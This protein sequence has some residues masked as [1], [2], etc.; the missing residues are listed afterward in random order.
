MVVVG[1][2]GNPTAG[3]GLVQVDVPTS[4]SERAKKLVQELDAELKGAAVLE[5]ETARVAAAK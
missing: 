5:P 4:L 2:R 1:N 3:I